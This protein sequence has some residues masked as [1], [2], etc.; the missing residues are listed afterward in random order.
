MSFRIKGQVAG[1]GWSSR[2]LRFGMAVTG[3]LLSLGIGF[4]NLGNIRG[5][6]VVGNSADESTLSAVPSATAEAPGNNR[7]V[8]QAN[9]PGAERTGKEQPRTESAET[10]PNNRRPTVNIRTFGAAGDGVTDDTEAVNAALRSLAGGGKCV[11]PKGVYLISAS[12][13]KSHVGSNVHLVGE[14]RGDSILRIAGMPP[15]NF[16]W[17]EGDDWS[18]RDLTIDM[19]NYFTKFSGFAAIVAI[20]HNWEISNCSIIN[21]GRLGIN[22][23]G[24]ANGLIKGNLISKTVGASL[25][26]SAIL[27]VADG[28]RRLA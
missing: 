26:N 28:N 22:A 23:K 17:C 21:I 7:N 24:G 20:G 2:R 27:G 3:L 13:I 6:V 19:Q 11:V 4:A 9:S 18:V 16:L 5:E 12:G 8:D 15:G 10:G 14:S 25:N 1:E